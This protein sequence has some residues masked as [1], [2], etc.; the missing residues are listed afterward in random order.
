MRYCPVE[1]VVSIDAPET[2]NG[3]AIKRRI[4]STITS[5]M[6]EKRIISDTNP[7][8]FWGSFGTSCECAVVGVG[9]LFKSDDIQILFFTIISV[10]A[11]VHKFFVWCD[12]SMR[13]KRYRSILCMYD[14]CCWFG[15]SRY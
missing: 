14:Y 6:S 4:G 2:I 7:S 15:Q 11:E 8:F 12:I 13:K 9:E 5:A 10:H 3:C 1:K